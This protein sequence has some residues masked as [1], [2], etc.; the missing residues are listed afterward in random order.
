MAL[1]SVLCLSRL[2]FETSLFNNGPGQTRFLSLKKFIEPRRSFLAYFLLAFAI[3]AVYGRTV[4][5]DFTN[6]DDPF[7]IITNSFVRGGLTLEGFF[8][9]LTT[10]YYE[11]WHP[12]TWWSHMLDCELFGLKPG[13][14]HLMSVG[15]HVANT[16]LVFTV[17]RQMTGKLVRSGIVAAFLALH[18]LHVESVAWL[19]ERKDVLSAFFF[20]L[21][22]WTYLRF[23]EECKT[24]ISKADFFYTLTFILYALGLMAKPMVVT[25]PFVLLLLDY[26]PLNRFQT[27]D[28]S[29]GENASFL[30]IFG[31]LAKEKLPLFALSFVSCAVSYFGVKTAN[32]ILSPEK[33]PWSARW[34]NVP[35]SYVGY[36]GKTIWPA[37][38]AVLYP[39]QSHLDFW[40]VG[41]ALLLL[42]LI[43]LAVLI[44][45]RPAP[46]LVFGWFMFLGMLVPTIGLVPVS[47][48]SIADRY[49]Y[50]P[51]IGLFAAAVWGIA[52]ISVR[53]KY[54]STLIT[55]GTALFL[56]ACGTLTWIQVGYWRNSVTLWTH[57]LAVAP[58]NVMAHYNL[59]HVLQHSGQTS[60]SMEQYRA[61][62]R[63]QPDH[64]DANLNLGIA[65]AT[66][67]E[68]RDATNY[69][70]KALLI[71][72]DY[73]KAHLSMGHALVE[74]GD[75]EGAAMHCAQA[76]RL[77]PNDSAAFTYLGRALGGQGKSNEALRC[78]SE[79]LR[80][81]PSNGKA[82][83]YLGFSP[84]ER[85]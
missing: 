85:K 59:G 5:F 43:S 81:D 69:L 62:L 40:R 1:L 75:F 16:V 41:G 20:L 28:V 50:L 32:N 6:Y 60:E 11:Y 3:L 4:R 22:V 54:R 44:L 80:L 10:S 66:L 8:W 34:A 63:I 38:L 24:N 35:V 78:F 23:V 67:G 55:S 73:E 2:R 14:H 12:V 77:D 37:N 72:P 15:F 46:Y 65:Y 76:V 47:V 53:W 7:L 13:W 18:P 56:L 27:T 19:S 9:S 71:K 82:R 45:T 68:M 70:A 42:V 52:E 26:W 25:F 48:Q 64:L 61:A 84:G 17:F 29:A 31:R 51:S 30:K 58:D 74:L 21:S 39:I 57:C 36:L 49:T 33:I 79:A 83:E